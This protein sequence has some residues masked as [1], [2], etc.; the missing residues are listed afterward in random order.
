M[1]S[2][3]DDTFVWID[4]TTLASKIGGFPFCQAPVQKDPRIDGSRLRFE[5]S[6]LGPPVLVERRVLVN[7]LRI[8]GDLLDAS[9]VAELREKA[10]GYPRA[11]IR[12]RRGGGRS[13]RQVRPKQ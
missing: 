11:E 5:R 10:E 1:A 6:R 2:R 8:E 3:C 4:C 7:G 9:A 12:E 13:S